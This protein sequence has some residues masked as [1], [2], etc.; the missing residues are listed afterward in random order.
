MWLSLDDVQALRLTAQLAGVTT[1]V[2]LLL[3]TPLAWW[4][5]RTRSVFKGPVAAVVALPLVLPPTVIGFYLLLLLGPHGP[6]G[7]W[8]QAMGDDYSFL[9]KGGSGGYSLAWSV[10]AAPSAVPEPESIAMMLAG[11][12]VVGGMSRRRRTTTAA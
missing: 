4:L 5:S 6:V 3:G 9:V 10:A 2:L 11:I 12:A 1:F 7:L 8:M